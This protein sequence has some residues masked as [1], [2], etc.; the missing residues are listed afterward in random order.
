M[1]KVNVV[2]AEIS[3]RLRLQ[4]VANEPIGAGEVIVQAH[5]EEIKDQRTW[6]TLQLDETRHLRND[7]L[8][9]VDHS[10]APNALL[11]VERLALVA[12]HDIAAGMPI[13]SFTRAP[14]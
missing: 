1:S 4:L 3:P 7:F 9:F 8:N 2:S 14:R 11:D 5:K 10:C 13:P 6:R 12:I